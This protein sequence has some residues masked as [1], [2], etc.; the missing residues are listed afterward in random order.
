MGAVGNFLQARA[1]RPVLLA[2]QDAAVT[3]R[4]L[5]EAQHALALSVVSLGL[6][7]GLGLSWLRQRR[8]AEAN[9]FSR[10]SRPRPTSSR[11][12]SAFE[13]AAWEE[14]GLDRP[15][16]FASGQLLSAA[17]ARAPH[18]DEVSAEREPIAAWRERVPWR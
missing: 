5:L 8:E 14:A 12:C 3:G 1:A 9:L 16:R 15:L 6:C 17:I 11:V 13:V 4:T 18:F 10:A 7:L 2:V